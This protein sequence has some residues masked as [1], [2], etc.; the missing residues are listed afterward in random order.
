MGFNWPKGIKEVPLLSEIVNNGKDI[1]L[2]NNEIIEN[3]DTIIL[4][5]GY[6]HHFPFLPDSL[7]LKTKNVLYPS[8][9]Y[10][11]VVYTNNPRL[12]YLGMQDQWYTFSMFDLQSL[13]VKDTILKKIELPSIAMMINDAASWSLRYSSL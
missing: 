10:K 9:L 5:T 4:C 11:G 12:F 13:F 8:G 1:K 2:I 7:K 3:I 6:L